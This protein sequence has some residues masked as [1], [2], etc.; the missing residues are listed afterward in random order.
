[1][2]VV[3]DFRGLLEIRCGEV[4]GASRPRAPKALKAMLLFRTTGPGRPRY[5]TFPSPSIPNRNCAISAQSRKMP[6][7]FDASLTPSN[8][9]RK[10]FRNIPNTF[11][12]IR[13]HSI[14]LPNPLPDILLTL[15]ELPGGLRDVR[16]PSRKFPKTLPHIRE[17]TRKAPNTLRH[18]RKCSRDLPRTLR[19]IPER[20]QD[21]PFAFPDIVQQSKSDFPPIFDLAA[22][23]RI[24]PNENCAI[25]AQPTAPFPRKSD[26]PRIE[27]R[28]AK[29]VHDFGGLPETKRGKVAGASRP[30][31]P[32]ARKAPSPCGTSGP[33]RPRYFP[34]PRHSA[35]REFPGVP[36]SRPNREKDKPGTLCEKMLHRN[37][38]AKCVCRVAAA[39]IIAVG[40]EERGTHGTAR[41]HLP[42]SGLTTR[43]ASLFRRYAAHALPRRPWVRSSPTATVVA[44]ATRQRS[45]TRALA[46]DYALSAASGTQPGG[47]LESSRR[48]SEERAIPPVF[49]D[50][51]CTPDGVLE[52]ILRP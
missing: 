7:R 28:P 11:P 5:F 6:V 30:R 52:S 31:A 26:L 49:A 20:G 10:C 38:D 29:V 50:R 43:G 36:F 16:E 1:M 44:A 15:R 35:I 47:L 34:A 18:I 19:H 22:H 2:N 24:S 39:T 51:R 13:E 17:H 41:T 3:H 40:D 23:C 42:R 25:P 27:R 9:I 45:S 14:H 8:Y 46:R 21:V 12:H 33:R 32:K 37:F 4:A 48:L